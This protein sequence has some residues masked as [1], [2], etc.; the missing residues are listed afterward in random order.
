[1]EAVVSNN[2]GGSAAKFNGM[3]ASNM[4]A[5]NQSMQMEAQTATVTF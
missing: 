4:S 2:T 3:T 1:M 5:Q